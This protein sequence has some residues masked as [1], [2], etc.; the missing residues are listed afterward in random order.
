MTNWGNDIYIVASSR[1]RVPFDGVKFVGQ[2]KNKF[3]N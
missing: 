3:I 1:V 2:F